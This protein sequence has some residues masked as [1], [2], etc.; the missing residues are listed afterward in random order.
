MRWDIPEGWVGGI[1]ATIK[2][3]VGESRTGDGV[4]GEDEVTKMMGEE[5]R[6]HVTAPASLH[7]AYRLR[8]A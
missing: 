5:K 8:K 1:K 2:H 3:R 6:A 4:R 7:L